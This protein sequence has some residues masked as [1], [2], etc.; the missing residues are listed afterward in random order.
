MSVIFQN[1]TNLLFQCMSTLQD[2]HESCGGIINHVDTFDPDKMDAFDSKTL[3][4]NKKLQI[5][6][7]EI[8]FYHQ[9]RTESLESSDELNERAEKLEIMLE[10]V[11]SDWKSMR[12]MY[13]VDSEPKFF[14]FRRREPEFMKRR[15]QLLMDLE[16]SIKLL[17]SKLAMGNDSDDESDQSEATPGSGAQKKG[18]SQQEDKF[19]Q[20]GDFIDISDALRKQK[21]VR[22][23]QDAQMREFNKEMEALKVKNQQINDGLD[24]GIKLLEG[25]NR[26]ADR[27]QRQIDQINKGLDKAQTQASGQVKFVIVALAVLFCTLVLAIGVIVAAVTI[28]PPS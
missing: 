8:K 6:R 12:E 13:Q 21:L 22:R 1:R 4:V 10:S 20:D 9:Y 25:M 17:N 15:N 24:E 28:Q 18:K 26:K 7:R 11:R 5:L 27:L 19:E 2:I 23:Q 3:E 16:T 14:S